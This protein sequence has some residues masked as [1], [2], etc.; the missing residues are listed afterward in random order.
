MTL[1]ERIL[2]SSHPPDNLGASA[3]V[4][5]DGVEVA[6]RGDPGHVH[7]RPVAT[8]SRGLREV[9]HPEVLPGRK[10]LAPRTRFPKSQQQRAAYSAMVAELKKQYKIS[11]RKW[12]GRMS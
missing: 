7:E 12:R 8:E 11:I 4:A 6:V 5:A 1:E 10:E 2:L 9:V 3:G